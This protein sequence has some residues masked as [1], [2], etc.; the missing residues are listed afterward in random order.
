MR[1]VG[2]SALGVACV[3]AY[4]GVNL[5]VLCMPGCAIIIYRVVALRLVAILTR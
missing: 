2:I 1:L 5:L 4:T 3:A